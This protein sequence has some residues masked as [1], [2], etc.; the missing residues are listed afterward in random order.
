MR[1]DLDQVFLALVNRS[2]AATYLVAAVLLLLSE[3]P[4]AKY[5]SK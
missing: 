1:Y 4:A 3:F 2:L 5:F